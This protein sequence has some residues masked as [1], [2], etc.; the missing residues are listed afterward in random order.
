MDSGLLPAD[1]H[2]QAPLLLSA[3]TC[4]QAVLPLLQAYFG[5]AAQASGNPNFNQ[6]VF[7]ASRN[8]GAPGMAPASGFTPLPQTAGK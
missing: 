4:V 2:S 8:E 7:T 1:S 5:Q 6:G 3:F